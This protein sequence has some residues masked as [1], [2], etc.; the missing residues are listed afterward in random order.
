MSVGVDAA[1]PADAAPPPSDGSPPPSDTALD[2]GSDATDATPMDGTANDADAGLPR[3]LHSLA[4]FSADLPT[5]DLAPLLA[6][7]GDA[8]VVALGESIH[9][10]GGYYRMKERIFRFLVETAGYRGFAIENPWPQADQVSEYVRTC[11]GDPEDIVREGLF[12]V[13]ASASL[14]DIAQ[15][16]CTWNQEHPDDPLVFFGFDVQQPWDDGP[17]LRA[18]LQEHAGSDA[19]TLIAGT[20]SCDGAFAADAAEYFASPIRRQVPTG[21]HEACIAGLDAIGAFL[22]AERSRL[23]GDIG[24]NAYDMGVVHLVGLRSW[25]DAAFQGP[26]NPFGPNDFPAAFEARDRGMAQVFQTLWRIR[27]AEAKT[28]LWAHNTHIATDYS[29][30][31]GSFSGGKSMGTFLADDLGERF[32]AIGLFGYDVEVNWINVRMG[33]IPVPSRDDGETLLNELG[34]PYLFVDLDFPGAEMPLFAPGARVGLQREVMVPRD[35]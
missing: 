25:Q 1:P 26:N 19:E 28:V 34:V 33:S 20:E 4:G 30:V 6:T 14:R 3:G 23:V 16:M 22:E 10:S 24:V 17:A 32:T 12:G 5:G 8:D 9:T 35:Q 29:N 21:A 11:E 27:A 13:W 31:S 15:Y 18:F 7:V 2:A